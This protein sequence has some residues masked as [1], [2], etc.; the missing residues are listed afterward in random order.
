MRVAASALTACLLT[1]GALLSAAPA[2]DAGDS[3]TIGGPLLAS[4]GTVV[5][6]GPGV[7]PLPQHITARSW[8]VADLD[9]GAV[10]A[11]RGAHVK[12]LPASTLKTLTAI[13]L[14]PRLHR[15]QTF[16]ATYRDATVDGTRVGLVPGYHYRIGKLFQAMLMV[17]AND[18]ADA[19]AQ[20]N[21]GIGKT[22]S[23]MNA[24]AR[25][26]QADDTH[27]M[28]PSGL[29]GPGESESAYDLALFARAAMAMPVFRR[30]VETVRSPIPA[31]HH[32]H[33]QM[34]THNYLLYTYRGDLG[35]KN[36]YTV[37]A[38]ATYWT[39]ARR[40]G[41]TVLVTLMDANPDFWPDARS[42]LAWGFHADGTVQPVGQLVSPLTPKPATEPVH[43]QPVAATGRPAVTASSSPWTRRHEIEI[44]VLAV[45][46]LILAAV[47]IRRRRARPRPRYTLPPI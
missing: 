11:A 27:A 45:S 22:V 2:A 14:L 26:L 16:A 7:A 20:A 31:P 15:G 4:T 43:V 36:G 38:H 17:S 32:K 9:S 29:D 40:D 34:Y 39:V 23:E 18:A 5:H 21:G 8:L 6:A 33:Y 47:L 12:Y 1:S 44:G 25:H 30:I 10:L 24:E 19:L 42:L 46:L 28:T 41:H 13:T 37:A 35:G 3:S